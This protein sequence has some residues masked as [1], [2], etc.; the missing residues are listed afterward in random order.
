MDDG[1]PNLICKS[2]IESANTALKF[3][4]MC[5]RSEA[6]IQT[7]ITHMRIK[8]EISTNRD[9]EVI[10][11]EVTY[12]AINENGEF[13]SAA[14]ENNV[15]KVLNEEL[16]TT[17]NSEEVLTKVNEINLNNVET[18]N[19]S[20]C[21]EE[22]VTNFLEVSERTVN[23]PSVKPSDIKNRVISKK[24]KNTST[25]YEKVQIMKDDQ[26]SELLPIQEVVVNPDIALSDNEETVIKVENEDS[27]ESSKMVDAAYVASSEENVRLKERI[28]LK[29]M[30]STV[31][32]PTQTVPAK[33][34]KKRSYFHT[35]KLNENG[36]KVYPCTY[37]NKEYKH[38]TSLTVH[39]R[40]HTMERPYLCT[41]CGKGFKQFTGLSYHMRSHTGEQP[42]AC[43]LCDKRYRQ[44][45]SL[46]AHMRIHTGQR[47]FLC[48]VCGK[49][50]R[51]APDLGYH[52]RTH[53][54]EKPYMCNVC[55]KRMSMQCHLVQHMRIHTGEK[56]FACGECGKAFAS[57]TRLKRHEIIHTDQKPFVCTTCKKA[58]NR[59][60][61][62][63]VHMMTHTDERPH[64]CKI[65]GKGFIQA[66]CLKAHQKIHY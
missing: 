46:T 23:L 66:H 54:K 17:S 59:A 11:E 25:R 1:L 10:E 31:N 43:T 12:E 55:G 33:K 40:T 51:Q 36:E 9:D 18:E 60:S 27:D 32:P 6:L 44:S 22:N 50:F 62:L 34:H 39:M 13:E 20:K 49:G 26:T 30:F 47:P 8:D 24:L 21:D 35:Y 61:T 19:G 57:T 42:Y 5:E 2:C 65:C 16:A 28:T 52:M 64:V 56:P 63:R 58:F 37:C 45:A 3:R 7:Y 15:D 41:L 29:K 4:S 14:C 38:S 53:T 48:S